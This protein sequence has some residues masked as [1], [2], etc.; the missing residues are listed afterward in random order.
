MP[1][2]SSLASQQTA[3][4]RAVARDYRGEPAG[5][6]WRHMGRLAGFRRSGGGAA[7]LAPATPWVRIVHAHPV[8]AANLQALLESCL[9]QWGPPP[10]PTLCLTIAPH[11]PTF[12]PTSAPQARLFRLQLQ[13]ANH[14]SQTSPPD[15]NIFHLSSSPVIPPLHRF[16]PTTRSEPSSTARRPRPPPVSI[17]IPTTPGEALS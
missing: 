3:I 1:R 11:L 2:R 12:S 4:A 15:S 5:A 9:D 8:L 10:S 17:A 13:Y 7:H 16:C 6:D 14:T